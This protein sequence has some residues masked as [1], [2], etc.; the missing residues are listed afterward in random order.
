MLEIYASDQSLFRLGLER[1]NADHDDDRAGIMELLVA[2]EALTEGWLQPLGVGFQLV[3]CDPAQHFEE[4]GRPP[5]PHHFL[6]AASVPDEV[7]VREAFSGS[8]VEDLPLVDADAVRRAIGRG[9]DQPAPPGEI[10]TLSELKWTAVRVLAPTPDPINL[11]VTGTPVATVSQVIDGQRWYYGP[12]S[13][14][15]GPPVRLQAIN[16]HFATRIHLAVFWDLWIGHAPGRVILEAGISR[17]LA[18]VGWV[19]TG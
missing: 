1:A 10:T 16:D 6:R 11:E 7:Y 17:V 2:V 12:T 8:A 14:T 13:G 15:A 5:V 18:R 4:S 19:R 3:Y 9:L